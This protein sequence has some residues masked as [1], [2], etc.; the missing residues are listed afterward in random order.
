MTYIEERRE[1]RQRIGPEEIREWRIQ[2]NKSEH[3]H[4]SEQGIILRRRQR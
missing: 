4:P 1:E 2:T 3:P